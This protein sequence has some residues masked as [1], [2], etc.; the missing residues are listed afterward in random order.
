M[1]DNVT[2]PGTGA[3]V[4]ADEVSIG[5]IVQQVQ[6]V[7]LVNGEDGG[8][9]LLPGSA[10]RGLVVEPRASAVAPAHVAS[11]GLTIAT[12]SYTAGDVLGAG[13][14]ITNAA[15]AAG[16]T[17][18]VVGA[19]LLDKADVVVAAELYL[20]AA[21]VAFGADN[22]APTISDADAE[23]LL[24]GPIGMTM[25]DLGGARVGLASGLGLPYVCDATS[26]YVYAITRVAHGVF[27]AATDLSLRL[28]LHRD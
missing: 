26:L 12:T 6:R 16:G 19:V 28:F 11:S 7:K 25:Q 20:A 24:P 23:K 8:T 15:R 13:W 18:R 5:G 17:G 27:T 4:G 3:V 14:E 2:L 9:D 22:A 10:A 21:S 1:A